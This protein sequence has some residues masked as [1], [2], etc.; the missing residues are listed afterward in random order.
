MATASRRARQ[1][2]DAVVYGVV[3]SFVVFALGTVVGLLVGGGLVTAKYVMFVLGIL[4]FG[5]STFQMRPDPPWDTERTDDGDIKIIKERPTGTVVGSRTETK[6]QAAVQRI[7]P[8]S[9]YSLPP[10]ERL[11]KAAKLFV[12]SLAVLAWSFAMETVFGIVG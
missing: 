1:A 12:A 9:R 8:L 5:Y 3:V 10:N 7:P 4:L 6:F 11:S 2:L